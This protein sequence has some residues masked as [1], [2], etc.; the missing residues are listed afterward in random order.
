L[1]RT[2]HGLHN[3]RLKPAFRK[4]LT[5]NYTDGSGNHYITPDDFATI[6]NVNPLLSSGITGSGQKIVIA[7]QSQIVMSDIETFRSTFGL[8]SNDPQVMLVPNTQDPGISQGDESESDLDLE[9]S[10]AV[11]R[12]ASIIFVY[13]EDVMDAVQYAI[14]QDLAP[15]VRSAMAIANSRRPRP[16]SMRCNPGH[17]RATRRGSPGLP[18]RET[19]APPIATTRRTQGWPLTLRAAFQK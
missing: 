3:F 17:S 12:D 19:P 10:G 7:G 11:A 13:S 15:V 2:I 16:I 5:A 4:S 8:S 14:D 18:H 1:I 9:W 6:Y